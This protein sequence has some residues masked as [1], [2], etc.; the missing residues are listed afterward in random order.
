M[1]VRAFKNWVQIPPSFDMEPEAYASVFQDWAEAEHAYEAHRRE[2]ATVDLRPFEERADA[3][4]EAAESI[5][6]ETLTIEA[7]ERLH[8][9]LGAAITAAR[10]NRGDFEYHDIDSD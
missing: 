3:A 8:A 1:T 4:R 2:L 5:L 6:T 10:V 7:A 9:R